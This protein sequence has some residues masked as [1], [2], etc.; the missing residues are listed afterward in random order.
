MTSKTPRFM[1][2]GESA[3]SPDFR[4]I[5][6][7]K[8]VSE[9]GIGR[10]SRT[11]MCDAATGETLFPF[12]CGT[13]HLPCF[14]RKPVFSRDGRLVAAA[15]K[16]D[17]AI[18]GTIDGRIMQLQ[19]WDAA[20]GRAIGQPVGHED[21]ITRIEFSPDGRLVAS[22]S[23]N[24]TVKVSEATSG[25]L[26]FPPLLHQAQVQYATFSPD[27]RLLATVAFDEIRVCSATT[28]QPALPPLKEDSTVW[29]VAFSPDSRQLVSANNDGTARVWDLASGKPAAPPVR[30]DKFVL[31][32]VFSPDGRQ[33]A[34]CSADKTAR[35]W[36]A[37]TCQPVTPGLRHAQE[38]RWATFSPDGHR[39]LTVTWDQV[40]LWDA[41]TGEPI[42]PPLKQDGPIFHASFNPNGAG[43]IVAASEQVRFIRLPKE[44]RP[45]QDLTLI[46]QLL[47]AHRLQPGLGLRPVES[48]ELETTW[49]TLHEKYP[50]EFT[51]VPNS[52]F[53]WHEHEAVICE[54]DRQWFAA[55]VHLEK[56][57]AA[58]PADDRLRE[59]RDKV[60]ALLKQYE[61]GM[62][63]FRE[64]RRENRRLAGVKIDPT[65]IPTTTVSGKVRGT[66][67]VCAKATLYERSLFLAPA[68]D[69][70]DLR[71][72]FNLEGA[73]TLSGRTFTASVSALSDTPMYSRDV[74]EIIVSYYQV[75]RMRSTA[76][77]TPK[78]IGYR[79]TYRTGFAV[80]LQFG[81]IAD[82]QVTGR[83]DL[84]LPDV[85]GSSIA[86]VFT[87]QDDRT[88]AEADLLNSRG[89][90]SASLGRWT[91]AA[92]NFAKAVELQPTNHAFYHALAPLLVQSGDVEGYRRVRQLILTRF[93][94]SNDPVVAE[95]MAKDCLILPLA[96]TELDTASRMA[97]TAVAAATNHWAITWFQFA[98]G[99]AEYRQGRFVGAVEWMQKVLAKAGEQPVRDVQA[100]MVLAMAEHQ[101]KHTDEARTALAKGVEIAETKLP[102]LANG[103][104]GGGWND[105]I[106]AHT[107]MRE[108]K[109]LIEGQPAAI[110]DQPKQK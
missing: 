3:L 61:A 9:E 67:F 69:G 70:F 4:R 47:S 7:S 82:G 109:A 94:G 76:D 34:T 95:R 27:R 52:D 40:Q 101:S 2:I 93:S 59:R 10:F 75:P 64:R 100:Y 89:N 102:K 17:G 57:S 63:S 19:V 106:I 54:R 98:K 107:L 16:P 28:G 5:V 25:Q 58:S 79:K 72:S 1:S 66:N 22:A 20:T 30:H 56:M 99:L 8:E 77:P 53:A 26:V 14:L 96:G 12:D 60:R 35:I 87:A 83:I 90:G 31:S 38:A 92:E 48:S 33:I 73:G 49:Q 42:T 62:E 71:I 80:Y 85:E 104:L 78:D 36:D 39:L 108:A 65:R 86:G 43:L 84:R 74:P 32:S 18:N 37:A 103:D 46:A 21:E 110:S 88:R 51:S 29:K 15:T 55:L 11:V 23:R 6:A 81:Q 44:E 41:S 45:I 24:R 97:D 68:E 50:A 13:N 91:E 105:W